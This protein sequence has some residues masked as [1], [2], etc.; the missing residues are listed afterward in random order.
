MTTNINVRIDATLKQSA[1][2]LF[3]DLGLTMSAAITIFLKS[4]VNHNGI[5]FDVK[6]YTPNVET[7]A[8]LAEYDAMKSDSVRYKRYDSFD[9]LLDEVR[10]ENA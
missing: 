5:P 9:E 1:E 6:R 8:A 3:D 2:K 10:N 4:A 7:Q